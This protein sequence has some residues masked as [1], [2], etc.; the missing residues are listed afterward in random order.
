MRFGEGY[1]LQGTEALLLLHFTINDLRPSN[2]I[3]HILK[4]F[5]CLKGDKQKETK[6]LIIDS[7][8]L[9]VIEGPDV[10]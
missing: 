6:V 8:L 9:P 4:Y 10:F 2:F 7:L 5:Q 3:A 1:F